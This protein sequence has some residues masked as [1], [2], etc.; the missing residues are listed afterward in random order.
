MRRVANG[1]L[2]DSG[3]TE[4]QERIEAR[5]LPCLV[6]GGLAGD[7]LYFFFENNGVALIT[8]SEASLIVGAIPVLAMTAEWI[9]GKLRTVRGTREGTEAPDKISGLRRWI[10]ALLSVVGVWCIVGASLAM[11]GNVQGY[12]FMAG[13]AITW[14]AYCFLTRPL[15][16][17]HGQFFIVFWQTMFGFLGFIPFAIRE[18]SQWGTPDAPVIGHIV[19][20]GLCCSALG[21]WLYN[22][23]LEILDVAVSSVFINLIPVV[24]VI[25]GYC[26]L[27][28]RL[29]PLQWAGAVLVVAGVY[30]SMRNKG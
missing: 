14:V 25:A 23:A 28:D 7:T 5:D 24:T 3:V 11:S 21:Y 22:Y 27:G 12:V 30:L 17:R 13:A 8:A 29:T 4:K 26:I 20:L 15:F 9:E 19:F 2:P 1:A 18:I 16:K 6:G 10:G